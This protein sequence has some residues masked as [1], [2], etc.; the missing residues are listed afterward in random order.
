MKSLD[1]EQLEKRFLQSLSRKGRSSNTIKNYRTDLG[2]FRRYLEDKRHSLKLST[3]KPRHIEYYGDY[4]QQNYKSDNS[5]R[6][7]IQ[8][9]RLFFDYLVKRKIYPSNVVRRLSPSPKFVDVPRP[10][11]PRDVERLWGHLLRECDTDEPL[12]KA[13]AWRNVILFLLIYGGGLKVSELAHLEKRQIRS[14]RSSSRILLIPEK[15]NPHTVPLP[16]IFHQVFSLYKKH[17]RPFKKPVFKEILFNANIYAI[18]SGG[19]GPRGVEVIFENWRNLLGIDSLTPKSLRQA[20]IVTWLG[21][22]V[23]AGTI[24]EWLNLAPSYGLAPYEHCLEK[25]SFRRNFLQKKFDLV[26]Q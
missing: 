19:L 17:L 4:V 14:S 5:K 8:S 7:R 20:C 3:L 25:H 22:D 11:K 2:C 16:D 1:F 10:P 26:L 9:L 6:R 15:G 21:Q 24:K 23:P 12:Q 18:L 13:I